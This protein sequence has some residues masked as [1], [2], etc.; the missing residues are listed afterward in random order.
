MKPGY[1]DIA[2]MCALHPKRVHS[3]N[4][5]AIKTILFYAGL[6]ELADRGIF[7]TD[8]RHILCSNAV[9][10]D[11]VLDAI[12]SLV[13][14]LDGKSL[15]RLQLTVS[16]KSGNIYR[17]H[18][19]QMTARGY[20]E[21]EDVEFLFWKVGNRYRVRKYDLLKPVVKSLERSL[22]YGRK[23]DREGWITALLV[24][25][26]GMFG[27]IFASREFRQRAGEHVVALLRSSFHKDDPVVRELHRSLRKLLTAQKAARTYS[28]SIMT[29]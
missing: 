3:A 13:H 2:I 9:T 8:G 15:T 22:V 19:T 12:I 4:T 27:N 29:P 28:K 24:A 25:E 5:A 7:G 18:M 6:F 20:L 26:G 11:E 16:Q 14:Q 21:Q 17:L 10:G 1:R 23:P